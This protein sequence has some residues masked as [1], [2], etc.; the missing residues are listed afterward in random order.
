MKALSGIFLGLMLTGQQALAGSVTELITGEEFAGYANSVIGSNGSFMTDLG[1]QTDGTDWRSDSATVNSRITDTSA[2]TSILGV[3]AGASKV[4]GLSSSIF[5]ATGDDL[6]LFFVG[7]KGHDI[8]VTI[9]GVT[10]SFTLDPLEGATG[11]FDTAYEN[12]PIIALAIDLGTFNGLSGTS[13]SEIGVTLGDSYD[14]V[15]LETCTT[16]SVLS[17]VGTYS[18]SAVPVPAAAWLFGSGLLGLVGFMR[19]RR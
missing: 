18:V 8:D 4:L 19:R 16:N 12:D 10:R 17:F 14:C 6:K 11:F 5:D 2:G 9:G 13:F 1:N 3:S 15:G 7:S